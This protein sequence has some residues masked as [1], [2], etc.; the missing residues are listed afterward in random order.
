MSA[1]TILL[2]AFGFVGALLTYSAQRAFD[3]HHTILAERRKLY[4]QCAV[5]LS[6]L[7][8][9]KINVN[10]VQH[11]ERRDQLNVMGQ[12]IFVLAPQGVR[13]AF[14]RVVEH[15]SEKETNATEDG[16]VSEFFDKEAGLRVDQLL[17]EMRK[18]ALP[19]SLWRA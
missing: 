5:V 13:D 2:G 3:R 18:D 16:D 17:D 11:R 12:R 6:G 10:S 19:S 4:E 7:M 8:Y 14:K 1:W 9:K 15:F